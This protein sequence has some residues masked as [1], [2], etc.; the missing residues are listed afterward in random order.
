MAHSRD[1]IRMRAVL[2]T[3][4]MQFSSQL[5]P[6]K[7]TALDQIV[8]NI[9][10]SSPPTAWVTIDEVARAF[11]GDSGNRAL[12]HNDANAAL[13]RL[14]AKGNAERHRTAA[15]R[16]RLADT[17][18]HHIKRVQEQAEER[19][20]RVVRRLFDADPAGPRRYHSPFLDVL[21][22]VFGSLGEESARLV[23]RQTGFEGGI[24]N[25]SLEQ[26][27]RLRHAANPGLDFDIFRLGVERFF[28]E[29]EPDSVEIKWSLAQNLFVTRFLGMDQSGAL[30]SRDIFGNAVFYLDTNVLVSA[31]EP[32]D[33]GQ[34]WFQSMVECAQLLGAE[35]RVCAPTL[36]ELSSFVD[37]QRAEV[38]AL[39]T[40]VPGVFQERMDSVYV[41]RYQAAIKR[42]QHPDINDL[43]VNILDAQ[44]RLK[45]QYGVEVEEDAWFN[46]S[47]D[48]GGLEAF[49]RQLR[50]R[51]AMRGK[52]KRLGAAR[53]DALVLSWIEKKRA[54]F[55]PS[56]WFVTTDGSLPGAVPADSE[57]KSLAVLASTLMQWISPVAGSAVDSQNL[58]IG[59][60]QLVR[61]RLLSGQQFM[62]AR[63]FRLLIDLGMDLNG[64]PEEDVER[65]Y[66]E[67]V[68]QAPTL[69]VSQ[70][71]DREK[72]TLI[73]QT[74]L[75]DAE[76]VTRKNFARLEQE[77]LDEQ[78]ARIRESENNER[79]LHQKEQEH[80]A[81]KRRLQ[82]EAEE[83]EREYRRKLERLEQDK[84][85]ELKEIS[86][87]Q[88]EREANQ[89]GHA[90]IALTLVILVGVV[91]IA[92]KYGEGENFWQ[93]VT[94]TWPVLIAVPSLC[95]WIGLQIIGRERLESAGWPHPSFIVFRR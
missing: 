16:F 65:I 34:G 74:S 80:E 55:G 91:L 67:V 94:G 13:S 37:R 89:W 77:K 7:G 25:I 90:F 2:R 14:V 73:V 3:A 93:R 71:R 8:S 6:L 86:R 81:E 47:N 21:C 33:P 42:G 39:A 24:G 61:E 62:E 18:R 70:A 12:N 31:L 59:F 11:R 20:D 38:V 69:D 50:E 75:A 64:M 1:T 53:H 27:V 66:N 57:A 58:E 22:D 82:R 95:L 32:S 56:V 40:K 92:N 51:Q 43:F 84:A 87:K 19:L 4:R 72:L 35:L 68:T 5:Q 17:S 48:D 15:S 76:T 46:R 85:D 26:F 60:S 28:S 44:G 63:H 36:R 45:D 54:E 83:T 29:D 30:L 23:T 10:F 78:N 41:R 49:A 9:L 88:T 52:E 79:I